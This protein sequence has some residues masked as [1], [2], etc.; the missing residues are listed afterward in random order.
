MNNALDLSVRVD[1]EFEKLVADM[2]NEERTRQKQQVYRQAMSLALQNGKVENWAD[3]NIQIGD[4]ILLVDSDTR[5]VR[6]KQNVCYIA[7]KLTR[8]TAC[9]LSALRRY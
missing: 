9:G 5:V 7:R 2:S 4:L 3:G 6:Q 8:P 1:E